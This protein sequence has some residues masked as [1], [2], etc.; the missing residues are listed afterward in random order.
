MHTNFSESQ[1]TIIL[2]HIS[3]FIVFQEKVS[4]YEI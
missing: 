4:L 2:F 3:L 1:I